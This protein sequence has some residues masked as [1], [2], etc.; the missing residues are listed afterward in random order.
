MGDDEEFSFKS[1]EAALLKLTKSWA[2][3]KKGVIKSKKMAEKLKT[4]V[5][6]GMK[7]SAK[8][9]K[10]LSASLKATS[11]GPAP[12]GK[13]PAVKAKLKVKVAKKKPAVKKAAAKKK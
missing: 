3:A 1:S 12:A 10:N 4:E 2:L 9:F 7:Q 11:K 6:N 13:K 8:F 5:A